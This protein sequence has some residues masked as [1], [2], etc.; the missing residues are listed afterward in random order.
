M[1]ALEDPRT[2]TLIS[3]ALASA[4]LW[5]VMVAGMSDMDM[6]GPL[7]SGVGGFVMLS[8]MWILM[9]VAMMLP[10]SAP[11]LS[12][13]AGLAAKETSGAAL[14]LRVAAFASG[15][16]TI[17]GVVSVLLAGV[18]AG[19]AQTSFFT[20]AG[21]QATLPAAGVLMLGAGAW[22][23]TGVKDVC[24]RHCRRPLSYLLGHWREGTRGAFP[25]GLHHG[26][27]CLGCCIA[28]MGLMFVL[29]AMNVIWMAVIAAYFVAE[30]LAPAAERWSR[31]MGWGLVAG[32]MACLVAGTALAKPA[33]PEEQPAVVQPDLLPR[34]G[35][36][37]AAL[38]WFYEG[39]RDSGWFMAQQNVDGLMQMRRDLRQAALQRGKEYLD[40][41]HALEKTEIEALQRQMIESEADAKKAIDTLKTDVTTCLVVFFEREN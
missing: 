12:I 32:G 30:K 18:Q 22:Q 5:W 39:V 28:L 23:F 15:Y 31:W 41:L 9:M 21:T 35:A 13:Y 7:P 20:Q 2:I 17:W 36:Q 3:V 6:S 40:R 4:V 26:M 14:A 1:R 25:M 19:L 37:V 24:L 10:A 16:F 29:G 27:Y 34:C 8:I 38:T 33:E 11:V